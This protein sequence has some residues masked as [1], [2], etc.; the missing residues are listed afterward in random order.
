[1]LLVEKINYQDSSWKPRKGNLVLWVH[2]SPSLMH[3]A[4]LPDSWLIQGLSLDK[5]H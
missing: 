1:M 2:S 5:P 3:W 4:F